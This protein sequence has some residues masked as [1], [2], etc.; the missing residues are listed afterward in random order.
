MLHRMDVFDNIY[1]V[2]SKLSTLKGPQI[3]TLTDTERR[4]IKWLRDDLEVM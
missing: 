1:S 4:L 3:H 2:V